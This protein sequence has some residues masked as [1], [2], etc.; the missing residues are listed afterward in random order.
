[1]L[2]LLLLA[3]PL[4]G[5]CLTPS[6][7]R[8]SEAGRDA[9]YL[10]ETL[11]VFVLAASGFALCAAG[12]GQT[13]SLGGVC[14]LGLT[15]RLDG[16][17]ALYALVSS[18]M[19]LMTGLLSRQYFAHYKNR[20]RYYLFN[21][22]TLM[23]TLGVFLSD[24][25]Y[26]TFVF[27]EIM[28]LASYPWV[29]HDE[30]PDAMAAGKTYLAIAVFGGMVTL[31]GL[32]MVYA[33]LGS[34]SFDALAAARGQ[35][36]LAVPAALI[37][38]GFAAKAGLFP[39]YVWLPQAHP[40]APA[41]ASALLSG[42][43]TKTGVFG[44]LIVSLRLMLGVRAFGNVLLALGLITML[45]GA[46]LA[47]LSSNLKRVLACSSMS[48]IGYIT[49]GVS[50]AV[51]L[52]HEGSVPASGAI[53]H[54]VN[55]SLLKLT[56]FMAAGVIYMNL[57]KLELN[58]LQGFGRGKPLLRAA[59]LLGALGLAGVP[60]FN[61][62]LGKTLIHEGILEYA[63]ELHGFTIYNVCEWVFLFA[64]GITTA[65]ML[66]VYIALFHRR[67]PKNQAA[68][69]KLNGVYM[70]R[71]SAFA[72]TAS[73]LLIPVLG[74]APR[75]LEFCAGMSEGFTGIEG[76]SGVAYFSPENLKGG[77]ISLA[78]GTAVYMLVVRRFLILPKRGYIAVSV[79]IPWRDSAPVRAFS[80]LVSALCAAFDGA[81]ENPFILK[82]VPAL[83]GRLFGGLDRIVD[84]P[85]ILKKV[86]AL[87]GRLFGGLDRI[88]DNPFV[89]RTIPGAA[90]AFFRSLSGLT[91]AVALGL[92]RTLF[93]P[94]ASSRLFQ[95]HKAYYAFAFIAGHLLDGVAF[96]L[97]LTLYRN[98]P[99]DVDFTYVLAARVYD[100]DT[101]FA[102]V[103]RSVSFALLMF[104]GGLLLAL[105]Y[106]IVMN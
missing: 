71:R 43:L 45:L 30:T 44:M 73:M 79:S 63:H 67:H 80:A 60:G 4:I 83:A 56:L 21:Q 102:R 90:T 16:F 49:V 26:T 25:L 76:I 77:A 105:F 70:N 51:L 97:N 75:L 78:I 68:F 81:V 62:Y 66:K 64:A 93:H 106:L 18:F 33:K 41:P 11:I 2:I 87:A 29:V 88:V 55:H 52:G 20:T 19:W 92:K 37:L 50:M 24:D 89:L 42:V 6:V 85:F 47:L 101:E 103:T 82:K 58:D 5:L 94:N 7:A 12:G 9:L 31:M 104:A 98:N 3:V 91:D 61:G 99:I 72:L 48:Q 40:V 10:V 53:M 27:F 35:S 100:K 8:R 54:M 86:P 34:L 28:S 23:A 59:F 96:I 84:N 32:F 46:V 65:Y 36:G 74:L 15:F 1:M 95:P 39:L 38:V 22:I 57:H 17:R 14:A 13:A 69:D